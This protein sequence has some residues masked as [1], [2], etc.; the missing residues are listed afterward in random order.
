LNSFF[1]CFPKA[2]G[3]KDKVYSTIEDGGYR[4]VGSMAGLFYA[5]TQKI[6]D[7]LTEWEFKPVKG[8]SAAVW[9]LFN[10]KGSLLALNTAGLYV[11]SDSVARRI[12]SVI[13]MYCYTFNS[14]FRNTLFFGSREGFGAFNLATN[15]QGDVIVKDEFIF[16]DIAGQ[17]REVITDY[18]DNLWIT[19]KHNGIIHIEFQDDDYRSYKLYHIDTSSGLPQISDNYLYYYEDNIIIA[20]TNGLY[21]IT[22]EFRNDSVIFVV[23]KDRV[24]N[25][26]DNIPSGVKMLE[27]DSFGNY[28][29]CSNDG[30][31]VLIKEDY[32]FWDYYMFSDFKKV[33]AIYPEDEGVIYFSN[34]DGGF[35]VFDPYRTID[36]ID[37][38]SCLIRRVELTNNDSVIFEGAFFSKTM[39]LNAYYPII[40]TK[41]SSAEIPYLLPDENSIKFNFASNYYLQPSET[42]YQY[43]LTGFNSK[44]SKLSDITFKEYTN[45][46][47]GDY[48]FCVRAINIKGD[49]SDIAQYSFNIAE[50]PVEPVIA[51]SP[52]Y[53]SFWGILTIA[54]LGLVVLPLL[55]YIVV[56][57]YTRRLKK[58]KE[59]LENLVEE[60]TKQIREQNEEIRSHLEQI[61]NVNKELKELAIVAS[62]T[63]NSIMILDAKGNIEWVND[64][65]TRM[66]ELTYDELI[67]QQGRNILDTAMISYKN[68]DQYTNNENLEAK[69]ILESIQSCINDLKTVSYEFSTITKS[70]NLVIAKTTLTPVLDDD[71]NL[72]NIIAVDTDITKQVEAEREIVDQAD[73]ILQHNQLITDSIIY[74]ERLQ[75]AFLPNI[76]SF[77]DSFKD[78]FVLFK[79]RDIVSGDFYYYNKRDNLTFV[80]VADCTGHGVPGAFVS[81]V[82]ISIFEQ[83]MNEARFYD[84]SKLMRI[85]MQRL[86]Y[87][88]NL[89]KEEDEIVD[90]MEGC[91]CIIDHDKKS[92][93]FA[94]EVSQL[95]MV[96]NG[97][98]KSFKRD[99]FLLSRNHEIPD[100]KYRNRSYNYNSGD[101]FYLAT[102]G[103][104]DQFGEKTGNKFFA[105]NFKKQLLDLFEKDG[106]DQQKILNETF[107][108]WK[109]E[110]MQIDDVLVLGFR[111]I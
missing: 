72:E 93:Q 52:W 110:A 99:Q 55:I 27:R 92:I 21:N 14:K 90:G 86:H 46:S 66:Y 100:F 48:C 12:S 84:P 57:L 67:G 59:E 6:Y 53:H 39:K 10:W 88:L 89:H 28:W 5:S 35:F 97:N 74:A 80:M 11:I 82:A 87:R 108:N 109:G 45:L 77:K 101:W 33:Y 62:K 85:T 37:D 40:N 31:G 7:P 32:V 24:L 106:V 50:V 2:K 56:K 51:E 75:N 61:Q 65:F 20:S 13:P 95:F 15:N 68:R 79:P 83:V 17:V 63:D 58:Q 4:Y 96:S 76:S 71:G 19:L 78:W 49:T 102:D 54:V 103:Y 8:I 44:W 26:F 104:K 41:Q 69:I 105:R 18:H 30:V 42:Q 70:G 81:L 34:L 22:K 111:I 107:L 29:N 16:P 25:E 64:G 43:R 1:S 73:I 47:A 36:Y 9:E 23:E 38:F 91:L 3:I 60:R 94:G 98:V